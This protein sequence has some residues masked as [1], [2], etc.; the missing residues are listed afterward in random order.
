MVVAGKILFFVADDGVHGY[1]LWKSDGTAA[2]TVLVK[3]IAPGAKDGDPTRLTNVN[4]TLYFQA[5][6]GV[7]YKRLW[8]SDGTAGG[9]V[10]VKDFVPPDVKPIPNDSAMGPMIAVDGGLFLMAASGRPPDEPFVANHQYLWYMSV[11]RP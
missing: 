7:G 5:G 10:P 2:G 6:D 9:T 11:R 3:D 1:E 4:G 8:K